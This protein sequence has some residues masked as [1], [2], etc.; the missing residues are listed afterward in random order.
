MKLS[1]EPI[2]QF[3]GLNDLTPEE[4][5]LVKT[6][7]TGYQDKVQKEMEIPTSLIIH[8]KAYKA[9]GKRKKFGVHIKTVSPS[10]TLEVKRAA[11][12]DLA[13]TLHKAFKNMERLVLHKLHTDTQHKRVFG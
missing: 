6:L 7:A 10:Q 9:E 12:W 5:E 1:G 3:V 13:R 11:D 2:V 4:Q 8:I